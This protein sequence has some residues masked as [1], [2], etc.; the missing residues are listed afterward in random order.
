MS[1]L[2]RV[3]GLTVRYPGRRPWPW[4]PH[5]P[6]DAVTGVDLDLEKGRTLGLVGESGSGKSTL[7]RA[8]LRLLRPSGG[9]IRVGEFD[10]TGFG[11]RVPLEYRRAVQ[12]VWQDPFGSLHPVRTVGSTLAEPLRI[13]F[14]LDG[15]ELR[16]RVG[17]LLERVGLDADMAD[18]RAHEFSGGQRQR[19]AI[20]RA[21]AVRPRLLILDEPVSALDVS[22]QSQVIALLREIQ[23]DTGT[24]Y[25]FIAHDLAV[26]RHVS[27]RI[28]VM[29][30]GRVVETGPSD[31]VCDEPAHPYTRALIEAVPEPEPARQRARRAARRTARGTATS[32]TPET[33]DTPDTS[34]TE[35]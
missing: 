1:D 2:L 32:G 18:R 10:V 27:H 14:G 7:G 19:V 26:V 12:V 4:S 30:R 9:T 25:L 20:A 22:T 8:V 3:R 21:L 24:A 5:R 35:S 11:L 6:V 17:E 31:R 29:R 33:A 15:R 34:D 28:A 23:R 13:H 16:D